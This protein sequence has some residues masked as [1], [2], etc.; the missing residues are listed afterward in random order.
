MASSLR[1]LSNNSV[2]VAPV[3]RGESKN[4][5]ET[6]I[7]NLEPE[8]NNLRDADL[9]LQGVSVP[10]VVSDS[11]VLDTHPVLEKDADVTPGEVEVTPPE[12]V[13]VPVAA[14]PK[15]MPPPRR[16]KKELNK[17]DSD[18]TSSETASD[19]KEPTTEE[20]KQ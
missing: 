4:A 7:D 2:F 12:V 8:V 16:S 6:H 1:K 19:P 14:K 20:K 17:V 9:D 13:Q 18:P 10:A 15:R 11:D 5:V 3:G